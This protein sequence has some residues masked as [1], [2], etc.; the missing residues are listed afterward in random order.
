M[1]QS[2]EIRW[3]TCLLVSTFGN[4]LASVL[5]ASHTVKSLDLGYEQGFEK[6]GYGKI[7]RKIRK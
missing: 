4:F 3:L 5:L 7:T 6:E 2:S 1:I